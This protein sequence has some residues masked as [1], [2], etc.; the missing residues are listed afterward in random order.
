[1]LVDTS[2]CM[3]SSPFTFDHS[4]WPFTSS[5]HREGNHGSVLG[6]HGRWMTEA[7]CP[8]PQGWVGLRCVVLVHTT[9]VDLFP[10]QYTLITRN[11]E[12]ATIRYCNSL[13]HILGQNDFRIT[14]NTG[15][16]CLEKISNYRN[17]CVQCLENS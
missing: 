5:H 2:Q 4:P 8:S 13:H 17:W 11:G 12:C 16:V 3:K 10:G 9:D 14:T 7:I 15:M 6:C 1:V